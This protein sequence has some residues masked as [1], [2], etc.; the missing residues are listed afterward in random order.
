MVLA[1]RS[2]IPTTYAGTN[3]R[4]RLEARWASFF[5]LVGWR[6]TYEPFDTGSWIPDFLI[7]GPDPFL[8]EVGPCVTED[9]YRAKSAKAQLAARNGELAEREVLVLGSV[10]APDLRLYNGDVAAG[11]LGEYIP[12]HSADECCDP[13]CDHGSGLAFDTAAWAAGSVG[14][15][16]YHTLLCYGHRPHGDGHESALPTSRRDALDETWRRAGNAVQWRR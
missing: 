14:L 7:Q 11:L 13:D 12:A 8:V 2:G 9:D 6:W 3:F 16:V 4:S 5:D 15:G 1:T 10:V